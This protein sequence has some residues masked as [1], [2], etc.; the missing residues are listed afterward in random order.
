MKYLLFSILIKFIISNICNPNEDCSSCEK[1][2]EKNV[3]LCSCSFQ[4]GFCFNHTNNSYSFNSSFY[5]R[6]DNNKCYSNLYSINSE[7]ICGKSDISKKINADNYY[8][9]LNFNNSDYLKD[10]NLFCH[11]SL[12]N[13]NKK[14]NEDLLFDLQI[15]LNKDNFINIDNNKNLMYIFIQDIN[16]Q[17]KEMY[18]FKLNGLQKE[19]ITI[20][21]TEYYYVSIYIS[22]LKNNEIFSNEISYLKLGVKKDNTK[23]NALKK[24]KYAIAV[25]GIFFMVCFVSCFILFLIK[26]KRN[27]ELLRQRALAMAMGLNNLE[28]QN[29]IDQQEKKNKLEKLFKSKLKKKKYLKKYNINETTACSICLEEFIE[30]QS[31]VSITPCMHIFHYECLHNWLFMENS[32]CQ[33]PY[34]NYDLLSNK[35]PTQRHLNHTPKGKNISE[36]GP[37]DNKNEKNIQPN[38]ENKFNFSSS[39]RVIKKVKGN[40]NNEDK[41]NSENNELKNIENKKENEINNKIN[42]NIEINIDNS[43]NS[44]LGNNNEVKNES[45]KNS[46]SIDED[47]ENDISFEKDFNIIK[48]R[49]K[50]SE[51][52]NNSENINNEK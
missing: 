15:K 36:K 19:N 18:S 37:I 9:M 45:H 8:T 33:C 2:W 41:Y 43:I 46:H 24:Y 12:I 11:Y 39:E 50:K 40:R 25:I 21:I 6:Y 29:Q 17:I 7:N 22:L 30:N 14:S 5:F 42:N 48:N 49:I 20:K 3:D 23:E 52:N 51:I 31:L 26:Y 44:N 4:S 35:P 1:C 34:C 28:N 16:S 47:N 32:N 10:N 27:R 38:K 13:Y